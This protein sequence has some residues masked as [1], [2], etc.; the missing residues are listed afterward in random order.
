MKRALVTLLLLAATAGPTAGVVDPFYRNRM[1][2]GV[3]AFEQGNWEVAAR[4]LRIACFGHLEEPASLVEGLI[5]LAVAEVHLGDEDAF[6]NVFARL[7]ELE[8][9]FSAYGAAQLPVELRQQFEGLAS[10]LVPSATLRSE[11]A[12]AAIA[13]RA[14]LERFSAL[15]PE[16]RRAEIEARMEAEPDRAEWPIEMA[17]IELQAR[18]PAAA[19]GWLDRLS[20]NDAALPPAT[21]LRQQ[22]A[23]E[24][25]DCSQ[26][27]LGQPFCAGVPASVV[28]FRLQCLVDANLWSDAAGVIAGLDPEIRGRRRVARLERRV[29][30]NFDGSIEDVSPAGVSPDTPPSVDPTAEEPAPEI[31]PPAATASPAAADPA[32]LDDLRRRLDAAATRGELQALMSA[33]EDLASQNAESRRAW[34]LAAEIAYLLADWPAAVRHFDRAGDLRFDEAR[35]AFYR[36]V[37]L[38]ESGDATAAADV[39]RPVVSRIE[40][41]SFVAGYIDRILGS[42]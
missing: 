8:E 34:L 31:A 16:Q 30:D 2:S 24:A 32:Q 20:A 14:D 23:S 11:P 15:P 38:Y 5:R 36:A 17:R 39:L 10:R 18:R 4:Q 21:C 19:L 29:R 25:G 1:A 12:F 13:D 35:L 3:R 33:A 41:N 42:N 26:M 27:D 6:R 40:S 28:E 37:A 9:R 7:V 22:A